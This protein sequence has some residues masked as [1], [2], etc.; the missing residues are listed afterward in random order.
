MN[1]AI[2]AYSGFWS[3]PVS[4]V[5]ARVYPCSFSHKLVHK[6]KFDAPIRGHHVDKEIWTSQKDDIPH[7][8]K[9]CRSETLDID[10]HAVGIY[11][12]DRL[13]GHVLIE[14]SQIISSFL[15]ERE[16]NEVKVAVNVKRRRKLGFVDPGN[17]CA[18]TESQLAV[19]ILGYKFRII[20]EKHTHFSW[21]YEEQEMY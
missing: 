3:K 17:Y 6:I 12:E 4:S 13:V 15:Q 18:R 11:K 19:Q 21:Q 8:K 10:K 16:L 2:Y 1:N 20:K 14:L 5:M 9:D 7:C